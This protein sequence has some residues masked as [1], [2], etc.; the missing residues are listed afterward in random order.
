MPGFS[1][2]VAVLGQNFGMS[3]GI[4]PL[5]RDDLDEM[6]SVFAEVFGDAE[7]YNGKR[8]SADYLRR[9]LGG[10]TWIVA[11]GAGAGRGRGL[12]EPGFTQLA[13][14]RRFL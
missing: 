10:C 11:W 2:F 4:G 9:L 7:T 14:R 3:Y 1:F 12:S 8:P 13:R 6:L 5:G